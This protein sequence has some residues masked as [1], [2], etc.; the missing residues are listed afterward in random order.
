[1]SHGL[2]AVSIN[3]GAVKDVG[4]AATTGVLGHLQRVGFAPIHEEQVLSILRSAIL[5]PHDPQVV[6]GLDTLSGS[7]WDV[8]GASQLGR[9]M[10]FA[11]LKPRETD[12]GPGTNATGGPNALASKLA[13]TKSVEQAVEYIGVAIAET[14]SDIFMMPLEEVDLGN[15][16]AQYGIDSL[17]AVELRNMLVQQ[18]AAEAEVSIFDI[19]Q[20]VSLAALAATHGNH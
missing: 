9:D 2:P 17:V 5:Q 15:K 12:S 13:T 18:A 7:H 11:A 3:L 19:M 8:T 10:R 4:V 6:V 20:S 1:M 16:P 14:I